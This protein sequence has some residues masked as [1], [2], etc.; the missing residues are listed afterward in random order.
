VVATAFDG[1]GF[2][3]AAE[4]VTRAVTGGRYR[5]E[6]ALAGTGATEAPQG[7]FVFRLELGRRSVTLSLHA[8]LVTAE[9]IALVRRGPAG[10]AEEA[11]LAALKEDLAARLLARPPAELFDVAVADDGVDR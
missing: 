1:P 8:G 7:H 2:R 9:F 6:P 11:H 3:D 4:L 5:H 10:E